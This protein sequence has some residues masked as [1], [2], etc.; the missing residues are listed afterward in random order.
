MSQSVRIR[1]PATSANLGPGYD[2]AGLSL[3][4]YDELNAELT[5]DGECQI[6]VRGEGADEVPLDDSHL[7]VR[8]LAR[9]FAAAEQTLPGLRLTCNN[10]IPHGRGLGSSSAAIVGGLA[11]GRELLN[12]A[13]GKQLS[14]D[15]LLA[16][17]TEIEGHP[18]NVAP[19]LLGGF[20]LAWIDAESQGDPARAL[21]IPP[22]PRIQPVVAIAKQPL[23]TAQARG[24]LPATVPHSDAAANA[25]RSGL[26]TAAMTHHVEL[27][28]PATRDWLHQDFRRFA[29]PSSLALVGALRDRGIPAAISGAGPTVLALGVSDTEHDSS[30]IERAMI[31]ALATIGHVDDF[32]VTP[33]S[34]D[35][36]GVCRID[37]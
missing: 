18:D 36:E 30:G 12:D 22:S 5:D 10:R 2:C 8:S 16:L 3:G 13:F 11:L 7:V 9:A 28:M 35:L 24:L 29:Y 21:R 27:L 31:A 15:D 25:A 37:D 20:T 17:A 26:L 1:V 32:D 6:V 23:A 19:A 33:L 4:L 14:D 34:V